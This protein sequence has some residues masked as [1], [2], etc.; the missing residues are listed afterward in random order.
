MRRRT[1]GGEGEA[2]QLGL[3]DL[4]RSTLESRSGRGMSP[5]GT[6]DLI[7]ATL[8]AGRLLADSSLP[9]MRGGGVRERLHLL[10]LE[11]RG[12]VR[13]RTAALDQL[14]AVV[15]KVVARLGRTGI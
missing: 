9:R 15:A 12:A 4:V 8:A 6:S 7:D 10:L 5:R 2:V 3:V 1:T 11:R 14:Q 13:A